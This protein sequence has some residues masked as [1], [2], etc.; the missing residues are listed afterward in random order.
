MLN[1]NYVRGME[2]YKEHEHH[3]QHCPTADPLLPV[4]QVG[5]A[6]RMAKW[7]LAYEHQR[8]QCEWLEITS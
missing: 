8:F 3:H 4:N 7:P 5:Q 1:V 6:G 2:E